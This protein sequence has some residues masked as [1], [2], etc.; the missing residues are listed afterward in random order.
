VEQ[1][2][3]VFL[4]GTGTAL[5]TGLGTVPVFL[6]GARAERFNPALWGFAIGVMGVASIVG[7]ILPAIDEGSDLAV[8]AGIAL[9]VVFFAVARGLVERRH[10]HVTGLRAADV[11]TATLVFLVLTVHSLPEGFAVGAAYSSHTEGLAL[12]VIVAI[13]L[14][15]VPEGTSVAIPMHSAGY[16]RSRQF[17]AAVATSLPQPVGAVVA[18]LL[19]EEVRSLL[20]VSLAFAAGAMLALVLVE[21]IPRAIGSGNRSGALAGA[22][23]GGAMMIGLSAALG[24]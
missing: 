24:V 21:L 8:A 10:H 4:A 14:H 7:L 16:S 12:F 9:G 19:V 5:A 18:Y 1:A 13:A 22:L 15:N 11:R 20:A 6:L 23:A 2:F 17:W 3:L